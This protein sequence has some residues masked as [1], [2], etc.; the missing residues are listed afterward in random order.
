LLFEIK[1]LA[2]AADQPR[3]AS[4]QSSASTILLRFAMFAKLSALLLAASMGLLGLTL[5]SPAWAHAHLVK[6][7]PAAGGTVAASP[8]EVRLKFSEGVEPRF[9]GVTIAG[10]AGEA[11]AT[12]KPGVD[13]V[14]ANTLVV[15]IGEKL[16]PGLYK[17]TWHA[18]SVD[19]HKTQGGFQFTVEP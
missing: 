6:S 2:F 12:G 1:T 11:I 8:T 15:S 17:V 5:A 10:P 7:T 16:K 13:P 4:S 9:S 14:D 3:L 19:T 18:V